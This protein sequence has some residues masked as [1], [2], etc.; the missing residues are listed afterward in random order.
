MT[1][2]R[3]I[4]VSI[5]MMLSLFSTIAS[6]QNSTS[7]DNIKPQWLN[8]LPIP[9]NSTFKYEIVRAEASTLDAA[10]NK[11]LAELISSSGLSHGI[12]V[13]SQYN[14]NE[15][16]SQVWNNGKL[17]EQINYN[18]ETTT[19][20]KSKENEIF[21]ESIDEYWTRDNSG[22]YFLTKLYAKSELDRAPL[23]DNIELTTKYGVQGLWRSAIV[24]GWGQLYK[25]S[26][27]KGGLIMGGTVVTIGGIIYTETM[28]KDYMNKISKTH[29]TNNMRAYKTRADNFATGRNICIGALGALY[30]YNLIDAIVA[31]GARRVV[32]KQR[33]NGNTY[34]FLPTLST[35]G[36]PMMSVSIT[37]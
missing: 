27:L 18:T 33:P 1:M 29:N 8:K 11:C 25:G 2:K 21:V 13:S 23:F 15:K 9:T 31:P 36:D 19:S 17:T 10:R 3:K 22:N 4:F 26:T 24:P 6:A 16:L 20:A 34:A 28:R 7:S 32:V 30:V 5:I 37:F 12:V 35:E 14:S